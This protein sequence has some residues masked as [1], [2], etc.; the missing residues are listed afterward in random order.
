M[1]LFIQ[2]AVVSVVALMVQA[3]P[4][5]RK[6][7]CDNHPILESQRNKAA[8]ISKLEHFYCVT[9]SLKETVQSLLQF[10]MIIRVPEININTDTMAKVI[11]ETFSDRCQNYTQAMSLKYWLLNYLLNDSGTA[12]QIKSF[13][14]ILVSLQ[15]I[16]SILDDIEF[17]QHKRHCVTL[18][19]THYEKIFHAKY[20]N[21]SLLDVMLTEMKNWL[22]DIK[23]DIALPTRCICENVYLTV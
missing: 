13:S 18:T 10:G 8:N 21:T 7:N 22:I 15:T 9:N 20:D 6:V 11:V 12:H 23:Q 17:I 19:E 2:L 3:V 5:T 4:V 16:T 1:S 14:S